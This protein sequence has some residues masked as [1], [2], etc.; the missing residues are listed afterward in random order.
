MKNK[1][2]TGFGYVL[3]TGVCFLL[4]I[5]FIQLEYIVLARLTV[6]TGFILFVV[7]GIKISKHHSSGA[8]K[9]ELEKKYKSKQ[10]WE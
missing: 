6:I 7:G 3:G 10:P 2:Y 4:G 9:K 1:E 5:I 8:I